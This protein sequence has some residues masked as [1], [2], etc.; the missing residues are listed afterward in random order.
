MRSMIGFGV[1]YALSIK[2][3]RVAPSAGFRDERGILHGGVERI[4]Q[5]FQR[6]RRK[7]WWGNEGAP[8]ALADVEKLD[9]LF[10]FRLACQIDHERHAL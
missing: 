10:V 2:A 7:A 5:G 1:A 8:D 6:R 3:C 9:R 4:A